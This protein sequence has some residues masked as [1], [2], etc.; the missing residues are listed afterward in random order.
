MENPEGPH[1]TKE[2]TLRA[3]SRGHRRPL[4]TIRKGWSPQRHQEYRLCTFKDRTQ[5]QDARGHRGRWR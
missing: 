5:A 4:Q 2:W 1:G 3:N